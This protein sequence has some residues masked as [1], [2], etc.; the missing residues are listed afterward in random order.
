MQGPLY[1]LALRRE[2]TGK[3][4][5]NFTKQGA[6]FSGMCIFPPRPETHPKQKL[7]NLSESVFELKSSVA[8]MF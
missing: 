8:V 7:L 6:R 1:I 2:I 3:N 5:Q 4:I